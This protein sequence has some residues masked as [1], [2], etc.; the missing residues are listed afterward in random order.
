MNY[1]PGF[2]KVVFKGVVLA[3]LDK[4]DD[5]KKIL[6]EWKKKKLP[7]NLKIPLFNFI[8]SKCNLKALQLEEELALPSHI[9]L[10]R[11]TKNQTQ[12]GETN[13]TG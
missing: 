11:L 3:T 7:D 6:K 10:P 1:E 4:S 5:V 13:Y 9:P 8:I 12:Q 2:A